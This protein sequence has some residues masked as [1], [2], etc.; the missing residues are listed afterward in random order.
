MALSPERLAIR[1]NVEPL[2]KALAAAGR[3][4]ERPELSA[5][6]RDGFLD[7]IETP[8]EIVSIEVDH[9]AAAGSDEVVMRLDPSDRL[10]GLL[11]A[12]GARDGQ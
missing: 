6:V 9:L 7:L 11:L 4:L 12:G 8:Q 1:F 2:L 10:V 3:L 5:E